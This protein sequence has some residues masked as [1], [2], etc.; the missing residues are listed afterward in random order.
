MKTIFSLQHC[1]KERCIYSWIQAESDGREQRHVFLLHT[2]TAE[3]C[4]KVR[5]PTWNSCT[6]GVQVIFSS[7]KAAFSWF[8][9]A[10]TSS[11]KD[12][13]VCQRQR[14]RLGGDYMDTQAALL[15]PADFPCQQSSFSTSKHE[16]SSLQTHLPT[17]MAK[18]EMRDICFL[19]KKKKIQKKE[20]VGYFQGTWLEKPFRELWL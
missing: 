12:V 3:Y 13:C 20:K 15:P 18:R 4:R 8:S 14:Q 19:I 2:V 6:Q 1:E 5:A 17:H 11:L 16:R 10:G 9:N 7:K